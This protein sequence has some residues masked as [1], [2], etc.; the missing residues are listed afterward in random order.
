MSVQIWLTSDNHFGHENIYRFTY[1]DQY[2]VERMVRE[3]FRNAIEGDGY[4]V[5]RWCELV[6]PEH[7]IWHLGDVTMARSSNAKTWFCN[8]IRSLP[9]HKR[10]ILGNHDH[11]AIDVYRDAGFKKIRASNVIDGLLLT[12]YPVH[13]GSIGRAVG[14]VHGHTHAAPDI[15]PRY[16]NVS[17]E[18]TDYAP[19]AIEEAKARLAAKILDAERLAAEP[20]SILDVGGNQMEGP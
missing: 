18:R 20:S 8:K 1:T 19:I 13:P 3:R 6:R 17:V 15:G 2:G 14:N 9:G 10:L 16:L 11:L 5:Q 4:M 12:H 7:H